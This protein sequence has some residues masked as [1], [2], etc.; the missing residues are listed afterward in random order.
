MMAV[1]FAEPE[2]LNPRADLPKR[3]AATCAQQGVIVLTAGTFGNVIRLLPPLVISDALLE[4]AMDVLT[5][6]IRLEASR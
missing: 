2:S 4:D 1:E 6:A 5:D 3:I